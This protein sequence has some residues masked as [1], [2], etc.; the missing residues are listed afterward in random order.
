MDTSFILLIL[1]FLVVTY[2]IFKF[3][4]KIFVAIFSFIF[5]I[6]LIIGS[7]IGLAILDV[8][9]LASQ[10]NFEVNVCYGNSQNP[11]FGLTLPIINKSPVLEKVKNY[12]LKSQ[13]IE[14]T[15]NP[16]QFPKFIITETKGAIY[17]VN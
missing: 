7:V 9:N 15:K 3:I 11:L 10:E 5:L 4:K 14:P 2:L 12:T 8:N 16:L 6:I 1:G 17:K 13:I